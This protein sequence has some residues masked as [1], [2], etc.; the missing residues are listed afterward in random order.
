M[1]VLWRLGLIPRAPRGITTSSIQTFNATAPAGS[2]PTFPQDALHPRNGQEGAGTQR[3]NHL[4]RGELRMSLPQRADS[5]AR[6]RT[7]IE[8]PADLLMHGAAISHSRA[9]GSYPALHSGRPQRVQRSRTRDELLHRVVR[10]VLPEGP[11]AG[12]ADRSREMP[13]RVGESETPSHH[14]QLISLP[15]A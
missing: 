1:P 2:P 3:L 7:A 9:Q 13:D 12:E 15:T 6:H 5:N 10:V 14:H 4:A 11:H 8:R